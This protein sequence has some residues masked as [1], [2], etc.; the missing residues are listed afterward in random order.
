SSREERSQILARIASTILE[1][2]DEL[3]MAEVQDAGGTIRKA[4]LAD[5]PATAQTFQYYSDL[6]LQT[7]DEDVFTEDVPVTSKNVIRREP[8]GVC[9]C[10]TPFNFPMAAAS[11][12]IAPAIAAGNCIVVK[13]SPY[14]PVTTLLLGQICRQAGASAGVVN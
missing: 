6:L 12:K 7:P 14:T 5:V 10:I 9:A 2:S 1:R 3:A 4:N 11:W 13:P 8:L